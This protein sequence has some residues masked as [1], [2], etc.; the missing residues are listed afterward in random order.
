MA[1]LL[2][3]HVVYWADQEPQ[4]L[5]NAVRN[6]LSTSP[7]EI[8]CSTAALWEIAIKQNYGKLFLSAGVGE[9]PARYG[10]KELPVYTRHAAAAAVLPLHHRDPFD[11]MLVAQAQMEGLVLITADDRLRD[12]D[13]AAMRC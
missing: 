11:R 6:L 12:Y 8:V 7:G 2:D 9:I 10:W 5:S 13:V 1:Y 4:R 3:T